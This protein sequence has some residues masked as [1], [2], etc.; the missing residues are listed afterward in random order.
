VDWRA[1]P[2]PDQTRPD[3]EGAF[4]APRS[5]V[6]KELARIW[7]EVLKLEQVGIHDN[8]FDL[9]GHSLL[10]TQVISR[11][12]TLFQ[13]EVPLRTLFE[14]PMIEK[15]ARVITQSQANGVEHEELACMLAELESLSEEEAQQHLAKE[16]AYVSN[17]RRSND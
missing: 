13:V 5:P 17:T 15:L 16:R 3:L 9:G 1:L 12:R 6:E 7:S 14:K 4:V 10:A 2:V 11:I 8:F